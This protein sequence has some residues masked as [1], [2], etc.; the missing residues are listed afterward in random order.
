MSE[1]IGPDLIECFDDEPVGPC[2]PVCGCEMEREECSACDGVGD[3]D[4]ETLQDEDPLWY[5]PGD[6]ERCSE[7][8]GKGG[9]WYCPNHHNHPPAKETP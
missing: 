8:S 6:T 9:W 7:C 1:R 3:L 5:Q 4:W 2:C